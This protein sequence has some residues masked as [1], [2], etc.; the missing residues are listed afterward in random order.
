MPQ[1]LGTCK[2]SCKWKAGTQKWDDSFISRLMLYQSHFYS[3]STQIDDTEVDGVQ[4]SHI[5]KH[6]WKEGSRRRADY[7]VYQLPSVCKTLNRLSMWLKWGFVH[8]EVSHYPVCPTPYVLQ[9]RSCSGSNLNMLPKP[10]YPFKNA[11]PERRH[12]QA[13]QI[14]LLTTALG[15]IL[16][17]HEI[18][19]TV[20][21]LQ[22]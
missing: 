16:I 7:C 6:S 5:E 13:Q 21:T 22:I 2:N 8:P 1:L 11:V 20:L 14:C 15:A 3:K 19:A 18:C 9:M 4:H 17:S 12:F 10:S